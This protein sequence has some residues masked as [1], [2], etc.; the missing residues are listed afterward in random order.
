L[1]P[2]PAT[3]I[4]ATTNRQINRR[5]IIEGSVSAGAIRGDLT[6]VRRAVR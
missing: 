5:A 3:A 4:I 2:Q 1:A 6:P